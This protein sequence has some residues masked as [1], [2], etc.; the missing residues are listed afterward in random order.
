MKQR[1]LPLAKETI[2]DLRQF[3]KEVYE[4]LAEQK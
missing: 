2:A 3:A 4:F 1:K